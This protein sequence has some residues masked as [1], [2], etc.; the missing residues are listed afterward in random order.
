M[1][2]DSTAKWNQLFEHVKK[3]IH[4]RIEYVQLSI[5]EKASVLISMYIAILLCLVLTLVSISLIGMALAFAL[6]EMTGKYYWGFLLAGVIF[7]LGVAGLWKMR[8]KWIQIPVVNFLLAKILNNTK[9][10]ENS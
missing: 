1:L 10:E 9:D 2:E 6:A 7:L 3:Y 8:K 5:A 4:N